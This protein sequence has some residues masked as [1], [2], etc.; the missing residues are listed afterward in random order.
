MEKYIS[1][2]KMGFCAVMGYLLGGADTLAATLVIFMAADYATGLIVAAVFKRSPKTENGAIETKAG[3]K[4]LMRKCAILIIVM[5]VAR[6][7]I[8]T[9]GEGFCRDT[10]IMFFVVNEALSVLENTSLMGV[11]YPEAV[12]NALEVMKKHNI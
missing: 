8:L 9:G 10:V 3:L 11:P 5:L 6:L 4:G 7:E 12:K 1:I 2:I